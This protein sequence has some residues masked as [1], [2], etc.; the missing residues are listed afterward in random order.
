MTPE[1]LRSAGLVYEVTGRFSTWAYLFP[2]VFCPKCG[3][4]LPESE[5][6]EDLRKRIR[7]FRLKYILFGVGLILV[8][9]YRIFARDIADWYR[10]S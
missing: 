10:G 2:R 8:V 5:W 3:R 1:E 7:S 9:V 6:P 4:D